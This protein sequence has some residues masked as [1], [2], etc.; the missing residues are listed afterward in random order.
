MDEDNSK[1]ATDA[2]I[3]VNDEDHGENMSHFVV[4]CNNI[5]CDQVISAN[6]K[7]LSKE[8]SMVTDA[9]AIMKN[10]YNFDFIP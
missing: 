6:D 3:T 5:V 7:R 4:M 9:T 10:R 1:D 8:P 2:E